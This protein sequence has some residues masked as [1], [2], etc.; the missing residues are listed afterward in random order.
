MSE[1]IEQLD[2][3]TRVLADKVVDLGLY[4]EE[5]FKNAIS[6]LFTRDWSSIFTIFQ[7][8]PDVSPVTLSS[9]AVQ[10]ITRWTPTNERL[11]ML[12]ALQ[13]AS[14]GFERILA[15]ITHVAEKARSLEDDIESY[16]TTLGLD[17]RQAFYRLVNSAYVQLRGCVVALSTRQSSVI[18]S[19]I[20][21]DS[22]LD[23]AY[24]ILKNAARDAIAADISLTMPLGLISSI[25]ADIEQIGNTVTQICQR[26]EAISNGGTPPPFDMGDSSFYAAS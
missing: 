16:F 4:T 21:Q 10:L 18:A 26:L 25:V 14:G 5:M 17:G 19:A 1:E 3:E 13:Q 20:A 12:V 15:T 24:M 8:S 6:L 9:E 23:Q 7:S 11:R 2:K 22:V